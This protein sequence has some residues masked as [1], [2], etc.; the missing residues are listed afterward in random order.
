ME[1]GYLVDRF[2]SSMAQTEV[3]EQCQKLFPLEH[4]TSQVVASVVGNP[5]QDTILGLVLHSLAVAVR[6]CHR[7]QLNFEGLRNNL[8]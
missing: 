2:H 4:S 1:A 6:H 7:R 3:M 5:S 8:A